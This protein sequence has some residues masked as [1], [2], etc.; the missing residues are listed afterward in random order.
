MDNVDYSV[1]NLQPSKMPMTAKLPTVLPSPNNIAGSVG[2]FFCDGAYSRPWWCRSVGSTLERLTANTHTRLEQERQHEEGSCGRSEW[3]SYD[4]FTFTPLPI[5]ITTC[6]IAYYSPVWCLWGR[7]A[8]HAISTDER[9]VWLW[10][11]SEKNYYLTGC[12]CCWL[13]I[14]TDWNA[15]LFAHRSSLVVQCRGDACSADHSLGDHNA[16]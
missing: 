8:W 14:S 1:A 13:T 12:C 3:A 7:I 15:V 9:V 4:V 10:S 11:W 2:A 5:E 6:P 16:N